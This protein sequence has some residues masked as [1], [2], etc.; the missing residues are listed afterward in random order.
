MT[1]LEYWNTDTFKV[2]VISTVFKSSNNFSS[3]SL[4]LDSSQ[5]ILASVVL[6]ALSGSPTE[7]IMDCN[8][9]VC[10]CGGALLSW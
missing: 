7:D 8:I 5:N 4:C 9:C 3:C 2:S 10:D 1:I 6:K